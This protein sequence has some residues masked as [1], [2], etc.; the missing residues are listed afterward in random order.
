MWYSDLVDPNEIAASFTTQ[1]RKGVLTYCILTIC[2]KGSVY[3]SDLLEKLKT[4]EL[5]VSE[6]TIYPLLNRLKSDGLL[7]YEWQESP[8][9]PPRKYYRISDEGKTYLKVISSEWK[10]ITNNINS[11]EKNKG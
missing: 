5:I 10:K 7:E 11:L 4:H 2:S 3:S 8:N 9:G 6:G 1:V